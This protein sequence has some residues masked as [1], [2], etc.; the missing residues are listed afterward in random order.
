MDPNDIPNPH[1]G[2]V[3]S[4][5]TRGS[6]LLRRL[7]LATTFGAVGAAAVLTGLIAQRNDSKPPAATSHESSDGTTLSGSSTEGDDHREFEHDDEDSVDGFTQA[8]PPARGRG[9]AAATTGGS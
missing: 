7:T 5:R 1:P 8:T 2:I 4:A 9:R 3:A 6:R